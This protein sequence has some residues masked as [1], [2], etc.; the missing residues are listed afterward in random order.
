MGLEIESGKLK[1]SVKNR[2]KMM[3]MYAMGEILIFIAILFSLIRFLLQ[4][5]RIHAFFIKFFDFHNVG[6]PAFSKIG[7]NFHFALALLLDDLMAIQCRL[8]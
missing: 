1:N 5:A 2:Q 6:I 4:S 8:G 7:A 3:K